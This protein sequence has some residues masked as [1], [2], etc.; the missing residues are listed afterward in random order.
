M[1]LLFD[2]EPLDMEPFDIDEED[3]V[4]PVCAGADMETAKSIAVASEVRVTSFME[5]SRGFGIKCR[6]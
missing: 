4:D 6:S 2:I 1:L 5:F 3:E